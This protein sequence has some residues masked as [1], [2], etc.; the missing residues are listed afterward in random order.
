MSTNDLPN[1]TATDAH[2]HT[3]AVDVA[4]T[5]VAP[6]VVRETW[7]ESMERE[8]ALHIARVARMPPLSNTAGGIR[9]ALRLEEVR[10]L[11][12]KVETHTDQLYQ[13]WEPLMEVE[14]IRYKAAP[15]KVRMCALL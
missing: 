2:E 9:D 15:I 13:L 14:L 8:A 10:R 4:D 11:F 7:E 6:D 12:R 5:V 3:T 1:F